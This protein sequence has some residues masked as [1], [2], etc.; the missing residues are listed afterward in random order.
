MPKLYRQFLLLLLVRIEAIFEVLSDDHCPFCT[1]MYCLT[2][3]S[4]TD[5]GEAMHREPVHLD[6][7]Q[8]F[9]QGYTLPMG[10]AV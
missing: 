9:I 8:D 4:D 5:P 6:G 7:S 10:G 3:A 2:T 1:S